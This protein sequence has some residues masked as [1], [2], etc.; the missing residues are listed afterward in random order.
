[1]ALGMCGGGFMQTI[2]DLLVEAERSTTGRRAIA[3]ARVW[4]W[5]M[6]AQSEP[7]GDTGNYTIG[8]DGYGWSK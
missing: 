5:T 1:M 7:S 4:V 2:D 3:D 8:A 6:L